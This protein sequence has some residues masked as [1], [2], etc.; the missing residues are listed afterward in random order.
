M[1]KDK[2]RYI[3]RMSEGL[4]E[5]IKRAAD[6]N[7]RSMNSEILFHL[8]LLYPPPNVPRAENEKAGSPTTA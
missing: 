7:H 1:P 4:R 8:E 5:R 2:D 3:I 6:S